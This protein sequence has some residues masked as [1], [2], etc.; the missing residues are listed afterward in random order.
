MNM[1]YVSCL[2]CGTIVQKSSLA[3][4]EVKCSNCRT[5]LK[6]YVNNG[7]VIVEKKDESTKN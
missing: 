2:V 6:I 5:M 7:I 1:H 4:T 3:F